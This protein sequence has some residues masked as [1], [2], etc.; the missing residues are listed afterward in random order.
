MKLYENDRTQYFSKRVGYYSAVLTAIATV[1][2]FAIAVLTPPFSGPLCKSGCFKYPYLDIASRFPR[3]YYWMYPA[4][5]MNILF[6]P[7]MASIHLYAT[8]SKKVYSLS[9]LLFSVI[10][11]AVLFID[12]YIQLTVIQAS[13]AQGEA[14][15]IALLTQ[16]NPHGI[17]IALEEIGYSMMSLALFCTIPVF[18]KDTKLEK[19]VRATHFTCFI[20]TMLAFIT[21]SILYGIY[22]EYRF[23][24]AV[25]TINCIGLIV[26]G[27]LISRIFKRVKVEQ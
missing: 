10:S 1:V 26:S 8:E 3:D 18:T 22:R 2:T 24:I 12:Y 6:V 14:D 4:L 20:L 9:A 16:Y 27:I 15:G 7:F 25:I 17:F 5:L 19:A 13:L 11:S 21:T 23:E